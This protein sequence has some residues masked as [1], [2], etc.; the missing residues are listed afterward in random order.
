MVARWCLRNVHRCVGCISWDR[1]EFPRLVGFHGGMMPFVMAAVGLSDC[2]I[3]FITLVYLSL[4]AY[5]T[6][7]YLACFHNVQKSSQSSP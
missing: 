2:M 6:N 1:V 5:Y 4:S 7:T 3:V